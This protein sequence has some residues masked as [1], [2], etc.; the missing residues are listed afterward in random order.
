MIDIDK[1]PSCKMYSGLLY[2]IVEK[3]DISMDTA[4]DRY[5]L[6]TIKQWMELFETKTIK[7]E[8]D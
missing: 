3:E 2:K 7:D 8:K 1:I 6:Y 5:G 4:R